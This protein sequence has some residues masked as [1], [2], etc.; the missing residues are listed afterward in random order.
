VELIA[1]SRDW[2]EI[3]VATTLVFEPVVGHLAKE[4]FFARFASHNGDG[5][6]PVLLASARKDG[7]RH[8][9]SVGELVKMLLA[10][11][12]HGPTNRQ[13]ISGWIEKW[14]ELS[15]AAAEAL[16]PLFAIDG[17]TCGSFEIALERTAKR[18]QE[19]LNEFG[20]S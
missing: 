18:H 20:L 11:P 5:V 6:T 14:N 7:H 17:I 1:S 2:M 13:V 8:L 16:A 19:L 4:Q 10:D 9:D 12:V 3:L 15:Y